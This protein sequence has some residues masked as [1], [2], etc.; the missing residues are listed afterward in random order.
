[1][2]PSNQG[3]R[4]LI[5]ILPACFFTSLALA[6]GWEG[7]LSEMRILAPD[8]T[9][10]DV[11][12]L[13]TYVMVALVFSFLCSVTEAVLL[14]ITPTYI[15]GLQQQKPK[16]ANLLKKLKQDNVDRSLAAILTLNTIAHTM[17]AIGSGAKAIDVFGNAWVG[18]FSTVITLLILF[19]SE[20]IP[21]T[22]GA[23]YWRKLTGVTA[24]FVDGLIYFL[25]PLIW[26][27]ERLTRIISKDKNLHAFSREEFA[28]M[29]YIGE[30]AGRIKASESRI[31]RN[32][33]GFDALTAKDIM[34]PR[35]VIVAFQQDMTVE[36][37]L[38]QD[39]HAPFSRLPVFSKDLDE[40]TGFVL[41]SD[42]LLSNFQNQAGVTLA[43]LKRELLTV[44]HSMK[45]SGLLEFLL[46]HRQH[47]V[48]T[49]D[50][51]G[52]TM[53]LVTLEDVVETLL[54][55]EIVDEMDKVEDM[56]S[57]ARQ[58]WAKRSKVLGIPTD[59]NPNQQEP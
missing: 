18:V 59:T 31:I 9:R 29:A 21:K 2:K 8:Y 55:M 25:Y 19:L 46:D 14:S 39:S 30:E 3:I 38:K 51:Y 6:W 53:G 52:G 50:E 44:P 7:S 22:L 24:L 16:L 43:S 28:A 34:T 56:Q 23:V 15:A 36:D 17:G 47:I 26:I 5:L 33:L 4:R 11:L 48:I 41:K 40:I 54:G 57:L 37:L 45:L 10:I 12:L 58:Q 13:L 1:M 42:V 35:T 27:S 20:I 49:L 32:L